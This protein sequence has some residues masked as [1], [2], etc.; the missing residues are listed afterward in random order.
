MLLRHI[1]WM[2]PLLIAGCTQQDYALDGRWTVRQD[3]TEKQRAQRLGEVHVL[4]ETASEWQTLSAARF[5]IESHRR[6]NVRLKEEKLL[7]LPITVQELETNLWLI[8]TQFAERN[9]QMKAARVGHE[10]RVLDSG[11]LFVLEQR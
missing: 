5:D 9:Y 11:H 4:S 3:K 8:R 10:L 2:T 1:F 7:T 6:L